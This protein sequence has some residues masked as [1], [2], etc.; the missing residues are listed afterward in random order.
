[1]LLESSLLKRWQ[2]TACVCACVS[3]GEVSDTCLIKIFACILVA[4]CKM[5]LFKKL[6]PKA[7][8]LGRRLPC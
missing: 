6:A 3:N 2:Q 1:M 5:F 8:Q 4:W 7:S